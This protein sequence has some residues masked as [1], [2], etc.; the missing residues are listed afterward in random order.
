[1]K[2][3]RA[4]TMTSDDKR[5]GTTT[6]F[7]ALNALDGTVIGSCMDRHRH[8]ESL[9]ARHTESSPWRGSVSCSR[10]LANAAVRLTGPDLGHSVFG[11]QGWVCS[12]WDSSSRSR[13]ALSP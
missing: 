7:A 4:G 11:S 5:H 13:S 1:M 10:P 2:R 6:L 12:S 9:R 8:E 3:G